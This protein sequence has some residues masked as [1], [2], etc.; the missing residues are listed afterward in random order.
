MYKQ[1]VHQNIV[2]VLKINAKDYM[3][4]LYNGIPYKQLRLKKIN[5]CVFFSPTNN[6]QN[7]SLI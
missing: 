1:Y 2:E 4:V 5:L 7:I 3:Q 6:I